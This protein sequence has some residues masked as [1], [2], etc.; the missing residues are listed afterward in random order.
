MAIAA[1]LTSSGTDA[2][3]GQCRIDLIDFTTNDQ[4]APDVVVPLTRRSETVDSAPEGC[5]T[6]SERRAAI[7]AVGSPRLR[8]TKSVTSMVRPCSPRNPLA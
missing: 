3:P 4:G 2:M 7:L 5:A 1:C 8:L 6:G